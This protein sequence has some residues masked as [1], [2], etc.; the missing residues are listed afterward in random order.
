MGFLSLSTSQKFEIVQHSNRMIYGLDYKAKYWLYW[1]TT[2]VVITRLYI[3]AITSEEGDI[4]FKLRVVL[5]ILLHIKTTIHAIDE[6]LSNIPKDTT[7][8]TDNEVFRCVSKAHILSMYLRKLLPFTH[9]IISDNISEIDSS[10]EPKYI[11]NINIYNIRLAVYNA[12]TAVNIAE[13]KLVLKHG[14]ILNDI[15]EP[16]QCKTNYRYADLVGYLQVVWKALC[17]MVCEKK[18]ICANRAKYLDDTSET[19]YSIVSTVSTDFAKDVVHVECMF[20]KKIVENPAIT[21]ETPIIE[22]KPVPRKRKS[23]NPVR[24]LQ[25]PHIDDNDYTAKRTNT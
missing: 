22:E 14:S 24:A 15:V 23:S 19:I 12:M 16:A 7:D 8:Q 20:Q 10:Y 13:Y 11:E 2:D 6:S 1:I 18:C 5:K 3:N 17:K 9:N 25:N 4:A 21:I